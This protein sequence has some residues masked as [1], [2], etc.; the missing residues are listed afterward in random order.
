MF[1]NMNALSSLFYFVLF[2]AKVL[3]YM[4]K[5]KSLLELTGAWSYCLQKHMFLKTD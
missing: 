2:C 1:L 4:H 3:E 5:G